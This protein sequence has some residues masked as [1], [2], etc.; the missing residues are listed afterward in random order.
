VVEKGDN[1]E[2]SNKRNVLRAR[3]PRGKKATG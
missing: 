3:Y 1:L 2:G